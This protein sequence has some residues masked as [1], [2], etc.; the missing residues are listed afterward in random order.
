MDLN[1]IMKVHKRDA[2]ALFEYCFNTRVGRGAWENAS[3]ELLAVGLNAIGCATS[4]GADFTAAVVR[5]CVAELE[6]AGVAARVEI[7]PGKFDLVLNEKYRPTAALQIDEPQIDGETSETSEREEDNC[8]EAGCGDGCFEENSCEDAGFEEETDGADIRFQNHT[9]DER[10]SRT[11]LAGRV[12]QGFGPSFSESDA[13]NEST[14][15]EPRLA[16]AR[17]R[18]NRNKYI[19]KNKIKEIN[20]ASFQFS[21]EDLETEKGPTVNDALRQVDFETE[22]FRRTRADIARRVYEQGLHAD[23]V[24]RITAAG[25]LGLASRSELMAAFE[26]AEKETALYEKS[27]GFRGR[28][29]KWETLCPIVKRWYEEAGY[30]WVKTTNRRETRPA[31]KCVLPAWYLKEEEEENA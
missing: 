25:R 1:I 6:R 10:Q 22:S 2:L 30:R 21:E 3:Y 4:R 7:E 12:P 9:A 19:N 5:G 27:N 23:L 17:A 24:D 28:R 26:L 29:T 18:V 20:K 11:V 16:C 8:E 31:P 15:G 13:S 14:E